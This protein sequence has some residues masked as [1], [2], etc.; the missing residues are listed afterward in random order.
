MAATTGF[1]KQGLEKMELVTLF[2]DTLASKEKSIEFTRISLRGAKDIFEKGGSVRM[3]MKEQ[4]FRLL[5]DN[6]R[7]MD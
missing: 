7:K 1:H 3:I 2:K 4:N 5:H 6:R